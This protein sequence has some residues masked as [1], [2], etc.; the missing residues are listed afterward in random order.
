MEFK[1][2]PMFVVFT[3]LI[4]ALGRILIGS[5]GAGKIKEYIVLIIMA[6]INY[7]ALGIVI[8]VIH[9]GSQ[10]FCKKKI[11][12][13]GIDTSEKKKKSRR[14]EGI[15]A[16]IILAYLIIGYIYLG[17]LRTADLND[18]ISIIALALSIATNDLIEPL[19]KIYCKCCE[20]K[21]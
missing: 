14:L 6:I 21:N 15:S 17:Y 8:L 13:S 7:V 11:R 5:V 18:A 16:G 3:G 1:E 12:D 2:H 19:G 9:S 10:M 20:G 4:I